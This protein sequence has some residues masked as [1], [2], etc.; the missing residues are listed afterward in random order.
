MQV[1]NLQRL[2]VLTASLSA[3]PLDPAVIWESMRDKVHQPQREGLIPGLAKILNTMTPATHPGL[4]GV[5]LSGAGPTI[6]ALVDKSGTEGGAIGTA[7]AEITQGED[8]VPAK[9]RAIGE[10]IKGLWKEEGIEVEWL[11]LDVDNEGATLVEL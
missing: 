2:A 1:Y 10:A 5:C 11:A 6:L 7:G 3:S 9:M 8:E 4:L